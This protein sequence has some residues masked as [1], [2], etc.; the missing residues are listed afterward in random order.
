MELNEPWRIELLEELRKRLPESDYSKYEAAI[1]MSSWVKR[2]EARCLPRGS[3]IHATYEECIIEM[4]WISNSNGA[5]HS[6][7]LTVLNPDG[8]TTKMQFSVSEITCVL[9]CSEPGNPKLAIYT[10][11]LPNGSS[12]LRIQFASDTELEDWLANLTSVCCQMN[13]VHGK[14]SDESIWVRKKL[15]T[16][17]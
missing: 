8:A 17:E 2:G 12:P 15:C 4:E 6:G 11:K 3:S 10:P 16:F 7:T 13:E 5:M 9:C 14:P 1:D